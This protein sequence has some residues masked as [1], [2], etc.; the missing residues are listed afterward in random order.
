MTTH[1]HASD[2]EVERWAETGNGYTVEGQVVAV[3]SGGETLRY[4]ITEAQAKRL[5][6]AAA[7]H[8]A[9]GDA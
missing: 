5:T 9:G 1:Q 3:A 4:A 6:Q 2:A 7:E 8:T